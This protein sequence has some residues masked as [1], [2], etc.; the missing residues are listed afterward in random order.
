M[1]QYTLEVC[2]G[3]VDDVLEAQ[4][5]G[6]DR[7]ELNSCLMFGGLT[8]SIGTLIAAKKLSSLPIMTMVR[9]RQ[10]GFCYTAAEYA[11]A[12]ADAEQLLEHG[13]D[14]LVFGFLDAD[15]NLDAKRTR[16]LARLAG[17]KIKVFHRAIDVCADW[18]RLLGQLIDIGIDRVLTSGLAPDVFYGVEVI[19]E[20][21][22]FAQGAIQI[23]PGAGVNLRN[24]DKIVEATGCDQIHVAR[25]RDV[26]DTSTAANR[27]IFFGGALY[28]PEDR[29]SVIDGDYIGQI[30]A[31]L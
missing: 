10:A 18:K 7:V 21:M 17:N 9:P 22:D 27:D 15:G 11:A 25:F 23:M 20:M 28:P 1:N 3:S 29:Y 24:V 26:M 6:A 19:R 2:C 8:P 31:R 14:G 30:R 13:S 4:R 5:G 16:E 12:L